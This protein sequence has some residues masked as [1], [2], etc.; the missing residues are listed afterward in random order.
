MLM[1][2][3][4]RGFFKEKFEAVGFPAIYR[5]IEAYMSANYGLSNLWFHN[6]NVKGPFSV[7]ATVCSQ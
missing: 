2:S 3:Q 5:K 6:V 1:E 4:K 7:I